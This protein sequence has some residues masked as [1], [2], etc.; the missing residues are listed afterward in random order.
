M[1]G[2]LRGIKPYSHNIIGLTLN[3]IAGEFGMAE[4]NRAIRDFGLEEL[5]WREV[6]ED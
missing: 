1:R 3:G 2:A 4:A 5:G 6:G